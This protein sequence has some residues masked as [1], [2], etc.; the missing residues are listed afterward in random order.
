MEAANPTRSPPMCKSILLSLFLLSGAC[1][2]E[3]GDVAS[4]RGPSA[5]GKADQP[6]S[7]G[8]AE[9]SFCGGQSADGCWCDDQCVGF[10]DCCSDV[11][12]VCEEDEPEPVACDGAPRYRAT[13]VMTWDP[14]GVPN[15]HWSP[16]IGASHVETAHVFSIGSLASAGVEV[17]AETGAIATLSDEINGGIAAGVAGR[18]LSAA[19]IATAAGSSSVDFDMGGEHRAVSLVSMMAPSPDWF[20][21]VDA[22][23]LCPDGN[24]LDAVSVDLVVLDAGTDSGAD[25]TSPD[26]DTNPAEPVALA[27]RFVINGDAVS[28]GT[29]TFV[30]IQ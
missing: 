13:M 11:V 4:E 2:L 6:G 16:P 25:F 9:A 5:D 12:S 8:D 3:S 20:V 17:M 30:R 15:P 23:S 19:P 28:I 18:L 24:W 14:S 7:C 22:L 29:L 1:A 21:G 10:G 26:I 27:E